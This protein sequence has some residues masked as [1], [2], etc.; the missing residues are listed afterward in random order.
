MSK[1]TLGWVPRD[2]SCEGDHCPQGAHSLVGET[3][4]KDVAGIKQNE[5]G[6]RDEY[7]GQGGI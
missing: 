6:K 4:H 3:D 7:S 5:A 2:Y 1:I